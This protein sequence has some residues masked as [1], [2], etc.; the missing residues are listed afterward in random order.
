MGAISALAFAVAVAGQPAFLR[1]ACSSDSPVVA[2]LHAGDPVEIRFALSD[3]SGTCYKVAVG[4]HEG[5]VP[6]AVLSGMDAFERE[7]KT[8]SDVDLPRLMRAH[9]DAV[10]NGFPLATGEAA[11]AAIRL[12]DSGQPAEALQVLERIAKGTNSDPQVFALAGVAAYRSDDV[13]RAADYWSRSL[14]LRENAAIRQMHRKAERELAADRSAETKYGTRFMLRY[15]GSA[16]SGET[17]RAMVSVLEEEYS[18][19]DAELGCQ[20]GERITAIVQTRAAYLQTTE[21]AEWSGG[22]YDGRIRIALMEGDRVGPAT[23]RVFS[24]ELVH[25]CLS[26]IGKWPA[27]LQEGLA[28]KLSGETLTHAARQ[29]VQSYFRQGRMPRLDRLGQD[30]SRLSPSHAAMAYG[31]S[32]AAV[33]SL[34]ETHPGMSYRTL[35]HSPHLLPQVTAALNQRLAQ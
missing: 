32:L 17:A 11:A 27:W 18:R 30:W 24:H 25:A 2:A 28:Q 23:R 22:Q 15:D 19:I 21:A 34:A 10:R 33:E 6:A 29:R 4:G 5:Y 14:A 3:A 16:I 9:V 12:L 1:T 7:R 8:A 13:R 26:S 20:W 31:F 35:V